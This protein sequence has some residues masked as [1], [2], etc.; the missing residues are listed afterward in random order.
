MIAYKFIVFSYNCKSLGMLNFCY[1][2]INLK[3]MNMNVKQNH[4]I[5]IKP[6]FAGIS[7]AQ[8]VKLI[9]IFY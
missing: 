4:R 7:I 9:E 5:A 8:L 3:K 2:L 1:N 6:V